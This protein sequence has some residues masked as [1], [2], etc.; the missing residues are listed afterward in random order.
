MPAFG[1]CLMMSLREPW[2]HDGACVCEKRRY[3][4]SRCPSCI[5]QEA[6]DT[7]VEITERAEPPVAEDLDQEIQ[8]ISLE[9]G[10]TLA[11]SFSL[12][13]AQ[14]RP[15]LELVCCPSLGLI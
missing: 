3:L 11:A 15:G 6:L 5:E 10:A 8:E 9:V 13:G 7:A 2:D 14:W 4:F 12:G 1:E